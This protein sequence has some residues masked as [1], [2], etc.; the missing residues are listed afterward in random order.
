MIKGELSGIGTRWSLEAI[1][2]FLDL[3]KVTYQ[4]LLNFPTWK[5]P[6]LHVRTQVFELWDLRYSKIKC[7]RTVCRGRMHAESYCSEPKK[8][9]KVLGNLASKCYPPWKM[10]NYWELV[11]NGETSSFQ[12]WSQHSLLQIFPR[13]STISRSNV[14]VANNKA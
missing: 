3:L 1:A 7:S 12:L 4:T 8:I 9:P 5:E 10:L 13:G 2:S 6:V 14:P 11:P